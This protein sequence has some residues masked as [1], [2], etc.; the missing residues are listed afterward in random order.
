[1]SER[2]WRGEAEEDARNMAREYLDQIVDQL[3]NDGECARYC[4]ESVYQGIYDYC[5]E[6]NFR[7][8][9]V[10]LLE[11]AQIL[12]E[13]SE[14]EEDDSGM[15]EGLPPREAVCVQAV[16]TYENA[17]QGFFAEII[18]E[19]NGDDEVADLLKKLEEAG[20]YRTLPGGEEEEPD[21]V[22]TQMI[23]EKA[24]EA[25][26]YAQDAGSVYADDLAAGDW[27]PA[28]SAAVKAVLKQRVTE[29]IDNWR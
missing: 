23:L 12:D 19:V 16:M 25:A 15:W 5:F 24:A 8:Q 14:Y 13:F 29:I 2:E 3:L 22:L 6:S 1:M 4:D 28:V 21:A 9:E 7:D 11:A 17:V 27:G 20:G 18:K 26:D 10:S